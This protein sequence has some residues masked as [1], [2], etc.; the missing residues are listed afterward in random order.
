M[1]QSVRDG[2]FDFT[3][4][5]E[6]IVKWM[7]L[8]VKGLVTVGVGNL[9]P[10]EASAAALPFFRDGSPNSLVDD[11]TKRQGWRDVKAR[12]DLKLKLY[13]FFEPV[14][15]LRLST[16]NIRAL[17]NSKLSSNETILLGVFP[18]FPNWPAD[19]QLG[20]MSMAWALGPAFSPHWPNFTAA[21]R[22]R[23]FAAAATNCRISETGNPGIIPRN[24]ANQLL[25]QNASKVE[26]PDNGYDFN[27]LYYPVQLLDAVI[28]EGTP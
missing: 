17:V 19:A 6:G 5:L 2:F 20:L 18:D 8:D 25:F 4:P 7:Y 13:T 16:D 24:Q 1:R 9:L 10:N 21:C 11:A 26:N 3:T 15:N 22:S 23:D 27:T 14:C 12:Q 28:V